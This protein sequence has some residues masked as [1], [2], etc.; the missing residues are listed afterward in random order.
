MSL[1]KT[2]TLGPF[3]QRI[4]ALSPAP[5]K[6][7]DKRLIATMERR[8]RRTWRQHSRLL[9][10]G[11]RHFIPVIIVSGWACQLRELGDGRRQIVEL[12]APGDIVGLPRRRCAAPLSVAAL[13]MVRT[14]EAPELRVAVLGA[15]NSEMMTML[16]DI[17]AAE[18]DVL[19]M[20]SVVRLGR[21][22]AYDRMAHLLIELDWRL[23]RRGLVQGGM[24]ALPLTQEVIADVLGLSVVHVNRTLQ[25]MR[26][27]DVIEFAQGHLKLLD[28]ASLEARAEFQPPQVG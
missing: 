3:G 5:M 22:T 21:Q 8:P 15:S 9:H 14:I 25:E 19:I 24:A 10:E 23:S 7:E 20:Q 11:A 27:A 13:T 28:R 6:E 12:L 16:A 26:R 2:D 18:S 4:L 17:A 1:I